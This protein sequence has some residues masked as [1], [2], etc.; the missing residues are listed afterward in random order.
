MTE[1]L[2]KACFV[3]PSLRTRVDAESGQ[4]VLCGVGELHVAMWLE[5]IERTEGLVVKTSAPQVAYRDTIAASATLT[6]RH[7]RQ[8][9]GPGQFAVV[10]LRVAPRGRGQ[11]FVFVDETRGGVIPA[12]YLSSIESGAR[13]AL[14]RG[15]REGVP[16]VDV[17][18]ALLD[19]QT[20]VRD[21]SAVAFE[22]A[23]SLG[24][25]A[26]VA[27]AGLVRLQPMAQVEVTTPAG[28]VG[29]VVGELSARNGAVRYVNVGTS[30]GV[31]TALVPLAKTFGLVTAL[32][33]RSEGRAQTSL[34]V[35]G[36]E[37][38]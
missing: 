25:Q 5:R 24:V 16:L 36:Y 17:E 33:S 10:T 11:G 1:A 26:A 8:S 13:L 15:V 22:V 31:V 9:G 14:Q 21:S 23:A 30:R 38:V 29:A 19:G 32:R 12:A 37:V 4:T 18:V 28:F 6:Y 34:Q 27:Q 35:A 2:R 3:D 7:V 20:H